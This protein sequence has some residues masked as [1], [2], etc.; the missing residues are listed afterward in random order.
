MKTKLILSGIIAVVLNSCT[1]PRYLPNVKDIDV[2]PY[3]SYIVIYQ[4]T[5]VPVKG[6]LL[7][8]DNNKLIVLLSSFGVNNHISIPVNDIRKFTLHYAQPKN[9]GWAIPVYTI[10]TLTHGFYAAL[11]LPVNLIVTI[12]VAGVKAF[13]YNN[14]NISLQNIKMFARFPQGL[15]PGVELSEIK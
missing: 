14:K 3:G 5:G 8:I 13:T 11:T 4:K 2:N 15:P 12:S 6:E 7:A 1:V 9:Y 10:A